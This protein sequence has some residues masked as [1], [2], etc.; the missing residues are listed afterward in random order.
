L[1]RRLGPAPPAAPASAAGIPAT[2][3]GLWRSRLLRHC[4]YWFRFLLWSHA[5]I[6]V[7]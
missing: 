2:P 7:P 6:K 3:V 1:G 4:V 5:Y